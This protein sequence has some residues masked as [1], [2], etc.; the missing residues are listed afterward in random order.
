MPWV[1]IDDQFPDH[2]KIVAAG[3][4]A[5]WLH[6]TALCYCNRMLT[7][8][9]IPGEKVPLLVANANKLADRL[10]DAGVWHRTSRLG[11]EGYEIH[12][13]LKYQPSRE[14]V[15][16]ERRKNAERQERFRAAKKARRNGKSNAVTSPSVTQ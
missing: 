11:V 13:F 10:V 5:A 16:E 7:D 6:V 9:F 3:P 15:L 1:R 2:P 8:G 12:D 4:A 14:E